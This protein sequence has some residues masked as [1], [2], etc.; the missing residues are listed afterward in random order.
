M[1]YSIINHP[2]WGT[3]ILGNPHLNVYAP[4]APAAQ[5][6]A[7]LQAFLR[8]QDPVGG[9]HVHHEGTRH[10]GEVE[11]ETGLSESTRLRTRDGEMEDLW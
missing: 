1:G 8:L 11:V 3:P 4:A 9:H 10:T 6:A 7:R 5:I 2:F